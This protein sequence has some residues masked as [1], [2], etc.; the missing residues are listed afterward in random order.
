MAFADYDN[1]GFT[2][3]FISNDTFE[4]YLF[5][6]NGDGTFTNVALPAGVAYNA[7]GNAIAGMGAIFATSTTMASR[8][9]LRLRCSAK[10]FRSTGISGMVSFR[11]SAHGRTERA[12]QP[13]NRVGRGNLRFRQ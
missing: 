5:H 9:F 13:L 7:Y 8:T 4:N 2:D 6:N 11:M 12:D 10:A 3:I 1:D